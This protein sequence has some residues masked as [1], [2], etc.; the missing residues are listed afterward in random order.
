M[1]NPQNIIENS[2]QILKNDLTENNLKR[3]SAID[4]D[5][6]EYLSFLII[7]SI[8]KF[9][10]SFKRLIFTM[11]KKNLHLHINIALRKISIYG[12]LMRKILLYFQK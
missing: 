5:F 4:S 2:V 11:K 12:V 6:K 9:L 7:G 3:E 1:E 8:M 10:N